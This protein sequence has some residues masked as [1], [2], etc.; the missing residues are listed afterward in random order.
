MTGEAAL[1]GR[2]LALDI[3]DARTGVAVTDPSQ[4]IVTPHE[5]VRAPSR[6]KALAAIAATVELLRPVLVVAGLPLL[7]NGDEGPQAR[8]VRVFADLLAARIPVPVVFEDER[9]STHAADD[10]YRA[11]GRKGRKRKDVID[12]IAAAQILQSYL[13]RRNAHSAPSPGAQ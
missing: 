9:Y 5:V 1:P 11:S 7:E 13:D 6:E 2:I 4:T 10:I 12:K 3:G 8:K